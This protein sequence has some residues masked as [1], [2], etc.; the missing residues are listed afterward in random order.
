MT[1]RAWLHD[2]G[3]GNAGIPTAAWVEACARAATSP[4]AG[5][6]APPDAGRAVGLVAGRCNLA[7][8]IEAAVVAGGIEAGALAAWDL[9]DRFTL[10]ATDAPLLGRLARLRTRR[11]RRLEGRAVRAPEAFY[12][13]EAALLAPVPRK[14]GERGR[15]R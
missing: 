7:G 13:P 4:G 12:A 5:L 3:L 14:E 6:T 11:A 9:F 8:G 2:L 1:A 10:R 15:K